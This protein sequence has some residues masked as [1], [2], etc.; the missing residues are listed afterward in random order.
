MVVIIR[1]AAAA[2]TVLIGGLLAIPVVIG[3]NGTDA[4]AGCVGSGEIPVI[5][6]TIRTIES[7]SRYLL[8]PNRG[9]AS[10][11][12]QY[13][14]STWARYG[15][16]PSAYLAPPTIQDQRA[17]IDVQRILDRYG[18][19]GAIPIT[20]YWPRALDHP[21]DLD[22][23]PMPKAGNTLTVR[24][25]QTRW[26]TLYR[27]KL[28]AAGGTPTSTTTTPTTTTI[29]VSTS[30]ASPSTSVPGGCVGS[31]EFNADGYALPL[32][33]AII[34]ANPKMLTQPH[35]DYPAI[36]LLVPEGTPVYAVR[37]GTV[38]RVTNWPHNCWD[39]G[40]CDETCGIGLSING[41]DGARWIYCHGS[42][43]LI[44]DG[45]PITTGQPIMVTGNTG[46]SGAPHL[47][48]E[49]KVNRTRRCPQTF[50]QALATGHAIDVVALPDSNCKV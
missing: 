7:G 17:T 50:L 30:V 32:P 36:D 49:I 31:R 19:V 3:G 44:H 1:F 18:D 11:A 14:D 42:Q 16:Y 24:Q 23:I 48:L 33:K 5:L 46:R 34:D 45:Q 4:L 47:H 29:P 40:R 25:Y 15:G 21:E 26:L 8:L 6:D 20:W 28:A 12:Y 43:L 37:G 39:Y 27:Q 13:I 38:A 9:G 10:G 2:T 35:H 22:I 41:N